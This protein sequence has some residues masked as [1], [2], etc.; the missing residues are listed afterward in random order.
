MFFFCTHA[1][2]FFFFYPFHQEAETQ[3]REFNGQTSLRGTSTV[4]Y[5]TLS[6]EK[7]NRSFSLLLKAALEKKLFSLH[8]AN[9]DNLRT[10]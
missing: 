1:S 4:S 2:I 8:N 9:T 3:L 5:L 6:I 7:I 10:Q